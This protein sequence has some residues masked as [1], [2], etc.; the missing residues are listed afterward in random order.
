MWQNKKKPL[1]TGIVVLAL[2]LLLAACGGGS[3]NGG[4]GGETIAEYE[5]GTVTEGEFAGFLGSHK[6]LN[7][8]EMYGFYEMMPGFKEQRLHEFIAI[9]LLT[10][11]VD[12]QTSKEA[13]KRAKDEMKSLMSEVKANKEFRESFDQFLDDHNMKQVHLEQYM[14]RQ[15]KLWSLFSEK[16]TEEQVRA[17]YDKNI[18]ENKNAY[19]STATVR[20]ILVSTNDP[21]SGEEIRS[22]EDAHERALEVYNKLKET[23]DWAAL[24]QEYSDD[25]GSKGNG[26]QYVNEN[27]DRW[28]PAF[29]QASIDQPLGEIGEPFESSFGY[30]VM[31][32]EQR[33][34]NEYEAVKDAVKGQMAN[35]FYTDY[36]DSVAD[37]ITFVNLPEPD[38]EGEAPQGEAPEGEAPEGE[39]AE[40][41][42]PA[43]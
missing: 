18:A 38:V 6:F 43:Q 2:A 19:V 29:R 21:N 34:S 8:D 26:G 36:I 39:A 27:V 37:L 42:A 33:N 7:Y 32:V 31:V 17:E 25:P 1:A 10:A 14:A 20:H 11:E 23:G 41:E 3:G 4:N 15:Y 22:L 12:E 13:D 35:T 24:A 16:F 28:D 9:K 30:H 40:G 5:G